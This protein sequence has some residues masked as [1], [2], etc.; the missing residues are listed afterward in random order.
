MAAWAESVL[1]EESLSC[2]PARGVHAGER[3]GR[4]WGG[5]SKDGIRE[6]RQ[7]GRRYNVAGTGI[8]NQCIVCKQRCSWVWI[9]EMELGWRFSCVA[10][11]FWARL[12]GALAPTKDMACAGAPAGLPA[13]QPTGLQRRAASAPPHLASPH[14]YCSHSALP[15]KNTTKPRHPGMRISVQLLTQLLQMPH[16]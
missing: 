13:A 4:G 6:P 5:L 12:L 3:W 14:S 7:Q 16:F 10:A 11:L 15:L 2:R 9:A 1:P 8:I